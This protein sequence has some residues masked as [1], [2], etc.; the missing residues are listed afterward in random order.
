MSGRWPSPPDPRP[1]W[2][3]GLNDPSDH[4]PHEPGLPQQPGLFLWLARAS[5]APTDP[6]ESAMTIKFTVPTPKPRNPLVTAGLQRRAGSH[7]PSG[8]SM[9]QKA[10]R[11]LRRD[12][13][14]LQDSP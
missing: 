3:D 8:S 13:H 11:A 5:A 6:E 1:R 9:R 12:L 10:Q 2:I 4:L 7:R 14:R